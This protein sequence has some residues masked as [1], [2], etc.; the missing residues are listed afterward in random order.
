MYSCLAQEHDTM[1]PTSPGLEPGPLIP[2]TNALTIASKMNCCGI[3]VG[4]AMDEFRYNRKDFGLF[5]IHQEFIFKIWDFGGQ[6]DFY[7][8]HQCFL[9]TLALYVLVWNLEEGKVDLPLFS[10]SL[11]IH[12]VKTKEIITMS[13][14]KVFRYSFSGAIPNVFNQLFIRLSS[15]ILV[16][17]VS[18]TP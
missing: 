5:T 4:I 15:V 3:F 2:G 18:H 7:T 16:Y 9:S 1:T 14:V 12:Q 13:E 6:E 11:I 8:T 17:F 10:N